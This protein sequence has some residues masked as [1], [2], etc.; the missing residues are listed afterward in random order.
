MES[1]SASA[2]WAIGLQLTVLGALF[3][4]LFWDRGQNFQWVGFVGTFLGLALIWPGWLQR[5]GRRR[6]R[7]QLDHLRRRREERRGPVVPARPRTVP[8]RVEA[9]GDSEALRWWKA[10]YP[11]ESALL[12]RALPDDPANG[13]HA[14]QLRLGRLLRSRG[15]VSDA[16]FWF[17]WAALFGYHDRPSPFET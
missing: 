9:D 14:A 10:K 15:H 5:S 12:E 13:D 7:A 17:G 8:R 16:R 11:D 1:R 2:L 3:L 4:F 6:R